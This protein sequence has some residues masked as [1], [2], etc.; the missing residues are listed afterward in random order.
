MEEIVHEEIYHG[1]EIMITT[2]GKGARP[3]RT[4]VNGEQ[5][6]G[7]CR[8]LSSAKIE[9]AVGY[10]KAHVRSLNSGGDE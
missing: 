3:Y 6:A 2:V 5:L 8:V 1:C 7:A 9:T 10:A 4:H